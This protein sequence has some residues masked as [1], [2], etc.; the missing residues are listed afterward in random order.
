[1]SD[2]RQFEL[3]P[4]KKRGPKARPDHEDPLQLFVWNIVNTLQKV[5]D[6][7]PV[8]VGFIKALDAARPYFMAMYPDRPWPKEAEKLP[9]M[10]KTISEP[11]ASVD[12]VPSVA[13]QQE[14][15]LDPS[16][17]EKT[18]KVQY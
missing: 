16:A 8:P 10:E 5:T 14:L 15:P 3:K 6:K 9:E 7:K 4:K 11:V 13:S 12:P 17:P 2:E 1:L 18:W